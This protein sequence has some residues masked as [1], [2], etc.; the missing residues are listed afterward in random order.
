[1]QQKKGWWGYEEVLAGFGGFV[2]GVEVLVEILE[3]VKTLPYLFR[4]TLLLISVH[5]TTTTIFLLRYMAYP[6]TDP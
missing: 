5:H 6:F 2:E 4:P 3:S 1:M